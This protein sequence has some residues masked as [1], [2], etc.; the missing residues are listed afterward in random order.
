MIE[1]DRIT[2]GALSD[3]VPVRHQSRHRVVRSD[4]RRVGA[5]GHRAAADRQRELHVAG[6]DA[7]GR[8]GAD[9]QVL[10]GLPGQALLRRQR[11]HRRRRVAGDRACQ[12]TVRRRPRQR[13]TAQRRQRQ[14]VRVP[15]AARHRRHRPRS[16]PRPRRPPHPR[17]ARQRQRQALPLRSVQGHP[18]RRAHRHGSGARPRPRASPEDDRRRHDELP[19][20]PRPR[21]VQGHRRRGRRVL[22]VR[23][24]PPGRPDRRRCASE[25]RAVCRRRHVHHPQD[26]ARP[27][28]RMHPVDGRACRG[29]R[30]G[31]VPGLAGWPARA[32]HR[33][34]GRRLPRGTAA[35]LHGV[36]PPDRRQRQRPG[37][38]A[39]G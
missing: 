23:R 7:R 35:E 3:A 10:R 19:A 4:R 12:A 8:L 18:R 24:G 13:A 15:G 29:D 26:A 27:A 20:P 16:E 21:A 31:R 5:P 30:Q 9:Q 1:A 17:V 25:S 14:H 37:G 2:N 32:R 22:P 33:R 28:G 39:R 6:S 36:R 38:G 11:R 34:Q